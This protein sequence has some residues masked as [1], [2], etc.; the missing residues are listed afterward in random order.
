MTRSLT[1]RRNK[2]GETISSRVVAPCGGK[3]TG[4]AV[5]QK[6][7]NSCIRRVRMIIPAGPFFDFPTNTIYAAVLHSAQLIADAVSP[8]VSIRTHSPNS[9]ESETASV[10][11]SPDTNPAAAAG[12]DGK[13]PNLNKTNGDQRANCHGLFTEGRD[14]G[15]TSPHPVITTGTAANGSAVAY[16]EYRA[17]LTAPPRGRRSR[18]LVLPGLT[19][20]PRAALERMNHRIREGSGR[21]TPGTKAAP[22]FRPHQP[23]YLNN[24][25]R[26][27]GYA[28]GV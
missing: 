7:G 15:D 23:N 13:N 11:L 25:T 28:T 1:I 21:N 27:V 8:H 14:A 16:S 9:Q 24:P 19:S 26:C 18:L 4:T 10:S 2:H 22:I 6:S 3:Y 20:Q 12:P 17:D 5:A